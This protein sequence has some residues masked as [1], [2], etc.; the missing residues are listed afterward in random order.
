VS[1]SGREVTLPKELAQLKD[2]IE[3]A[4]LHEPLSPPNEKELVQQFGKKAETILFYLTE[5]G[6][7]VRLEEG[8]LLH[9]KAVDV[10]RE[11]LVA[12]LQ[13]QGEATISDIRQHWDTSRKYAVPLCIYFDNMGL[14][15][16]DDD[17][18]RLKD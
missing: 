12:L 6:A 5:S 13:R 9:R 15:E 11:K 14:T 18:R 3:A 4:L 7:M 1:L 8:I 10:A 16:R 17:V 2:A